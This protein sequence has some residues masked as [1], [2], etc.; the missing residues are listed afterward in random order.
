M[1]KLNKKQ[2]EIL[3]KGIDIPTDKDTVVMYAFFVNVISFM[4]EDIEY[5]ENRIKGLEHKETYG[6]RA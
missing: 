1:L 5:L 4:L 6:T 3:H 2:F